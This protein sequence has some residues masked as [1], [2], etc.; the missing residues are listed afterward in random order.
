MANYKDRQHNQQFIV[1]KRC[2][3]DPY[4]FVREVLGV[5]LWRKQREI[6]LSVCH[7]PRTA[8]RS[9]H[10]SGK[11]FVAAVIL[12][13]FLY[14]FR[15]AR[16]LTTAPTFRQV[17]KIL[18]QEVKKLHANAVY[19]LGGQV[20]ATQIKIDVGWFALGFSTD[21]PNAFQGHHSPSVLV[22]LDEACGIPEVIWDAADGVLTSKH[23]RLLAIGNP[24]DPQARFAREFETPNIKKFTISAFDTPNFKGKDIE[25][26]VRQDWVEDKR[27]RWG[28][29]SPLWLSRVLGEFPTVGEDTLIPLGWIEEAKRRFITATQP[30]ELGVDVARYGQDETLIYLRQGDR[31]RLHFSGYGLDTMRTVGQVIQT[32]RET[33]ADL[34]KV[35]AIGVGA[36]VV[37]RL[38]EQG[39]PVESITGSERSSN[40]EKFLNRRAEIYWSLRERFEKGNIDLDPHDEDL[41]AQLSTIKWRVTSSGKIKIESKEEMKARGARSPDRADAVAYAFAPPRPQTWGFDDLYESETEDASA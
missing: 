32:L 34:V 26:L 12:L 27:I 20:L 29:Q 14:C 1:M 38:R 39:K 23:C 35:D 7:N 5:S 8:V 18:W 36:A 25:G 11:T 21:D 19:P 4:F 3:S 22:I 31:I 6:L 16:V 30:C 10:G 15:D 9:C 41:H 2:Q 24:T 37:D 40:T 13:W 33:K 17:E 28:E